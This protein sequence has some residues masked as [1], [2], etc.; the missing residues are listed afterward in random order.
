MSMSFNSGIFM[1]LEVLGFHQYRLLGRDCCF[2]SVDE[3]QM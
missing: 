2:G 3:R 1:A